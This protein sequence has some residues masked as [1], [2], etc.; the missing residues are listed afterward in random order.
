MEG[1][2]TDRPYY[3]TPDMAVELWENGWCRIGAYF[4]SQV[5]YGR[6][7]YS[8]KPWPKDIDNMLTYYGEIAWK[9]RGA[10]ANFTAHVP[11]PR[12]LSWGHSAA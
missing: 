7:K 5:S 1:L 11:P 12:C 4:R 3:R 2:V 8:V 6:E 9:T 10:R